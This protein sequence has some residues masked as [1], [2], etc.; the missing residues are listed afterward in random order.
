MSLSQKTKKNMKLSFTQKCIM[1]S[2]ILY[3]KDKLLLNSFDFIP[4]V[5]L[6]T[7]NMR[8]E[9][10]NY[11]KIKGGLVIFQDKDKGKEEKNYHIRIYDSKDY[12]IQFNLEI[13]NETKKNY[14]KLEPNFY[15]F[16]LKMGCIGFLFGLEQEAEQFKSLLINGP[17]SKALDE[18]NQ[19]NYFNLKDS[20]NIFLDVIDLLM[21]DMEKKYEVITYDKMNKSLHEINQYLIFSGFL[22]QAK[23]LCNTQFDQEDYLFNIYVDRKYPKK[24]FNKMFH[25]FNLDYLYPFRPIYDDSLIIQNKSNYVDLLVNHLINNFKEEVFISKKRKEHM[26][27]EKNTNERRAS[28]NAE[29]DTATEANSRSGTIGGKF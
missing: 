16:N 2:N 25:N 23:L 8:K 28:S 26:K 5:K 13:N 19:I 21:E 20:D 10:F 29:R 11:T 3:E 4:L 6:Y 7:S 18:L 12:S 27:K 22:D 9:K 17:D 14:I 24:L 1:V 15:C